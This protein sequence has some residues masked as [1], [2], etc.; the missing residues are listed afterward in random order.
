LVSLVILNQLS[1]ERGNLFRISQ[2]VELLGPVHITAPRGVDRLIRY[3]RTAVVALLDGLKKG[4][5]ADLHMP[6]DQ[7]IPLNEMM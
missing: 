6:P 1:P 5:A 4:L 2:I 3:R 7:V